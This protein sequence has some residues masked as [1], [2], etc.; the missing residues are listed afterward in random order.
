M[1]CPLHVRH[2][3]GTAVSWKNI[4]SAVWK[5]Q[6]YNRKDNAQSYRRDYPWIR[7]VCAERVSHNDKHS[8]CLHPLATFLTSNCHFAACSNCF[9]CSAWHP[10]ANT[11]WLIITCC[12]RLSMMRFIWVFS[13][14]NLSSTLF[15]L[16]V[17]TARQSWCREMWLINW[18][19][20]PVRISTIGWFPSTWEEKGTAKIVFMNIMKFNACSDI[21]LLIFS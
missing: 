19:G 20:R 15:D 5:T 12:L 18:D 6:N 21:H 13:T 17:N 16:T 7:H 14:E 2:L 4:L 10:A 9:A 1:W 8:P 11:N 3:A